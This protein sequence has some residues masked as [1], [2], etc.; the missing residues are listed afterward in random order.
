MKKKDSLKTTVSKLLALTQMIIKSIIK[1]EKRLDK[2][3]SKG[4]KL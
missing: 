1:I 2:L 3:E 4:G